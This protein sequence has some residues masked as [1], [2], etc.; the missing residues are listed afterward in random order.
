MIDSVGMANVERFPSFG[1]LSDYGGNGPSLGRLYAEG[2]GYVRANAS[3]DRMAR[4]ATVTL[5]HAFSAA[6][7]ATT[8]APAPTTIAPAA[9][10]AARA[11]PTASDGAAEPA[12][13]ARPAPQHLPQ[14][15]PQQAVRGGDPVACRRLKR[16]HGV[17][18]GQSWGSLSETL[19]AEWKARR[20]DHFFCRPSPMEAVGK[21][22]CVPL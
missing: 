14:P 1:E 4:T 18:P 9:T 8:T 19:V 5:L 6:P 17:V 13:A 3:W 11:P 21:Y 22:Q 12:A 10:T 20:C 2:N 16:T 15:A 7:K